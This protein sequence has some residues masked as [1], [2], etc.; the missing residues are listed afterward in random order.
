MKCL[1][2]TFAPKAHSVLTVTRV[3]WEGVRG[4]VFLIQW[5]SEFLHPASESTP[6]EVSFPPPL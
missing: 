3:S 5:G 4:V 2:V 6:H 1:G